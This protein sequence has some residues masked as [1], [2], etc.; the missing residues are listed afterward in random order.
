MPFPFNDQLRRELLL[1]TGPIR[2]L[3]LFHAVEQFGFR[4][5]SGDLQFLKDHETYQRCV[6]F[7]A[8]FRKRATSASVVVELY[9]WIRETDRNGREKLWNRVYEEF[10]SMGME[11][12]L[13]K[14]REMNRGLLPRLGPVDVSLLQ[15][16]R[17]HAGD[18]PVVLT[19]DSLLYRE[20]Q[21]AGFDACHVLEVA[22]M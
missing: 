22:S 1:D 21:N 8:S 5:L 7:I 19:I 15:L 10:E 3:V 16:A 13:V 11:E 9:H 14:L 6:Q 17:R 2:E 12:E 20:C 4:S 18:Q